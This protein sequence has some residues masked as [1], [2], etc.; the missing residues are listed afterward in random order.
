MKVLLT[1]ASGFIG[2]HARTLLEGQGH[3]VLAVSRRPGADAD[4]SEASLARALDACDG[5]LHLAGENVMARRWSERQKAKLRASR[6]ETTAKLV[7]ALARKRGGVLVCA[8]AVGYY[9][10]RGAEPVG[11][12]EPPGTDFLARLCQD[13]EAAAERAEAG[14]TRVARVRI[15]LVLGTDGG[16][17]ARMLPIA[18]LGLGGPLGSGEQVWPWVHV[19][20]LCALFA[21]LL[22]LDGARGPF[23]GTAPNPV[24]QRDF[25]RTLGRVLHRPAVLP[26]PAFALRVALGEAAGVLL[27]GVRA[28]PRSA[29][30]AGFTFRHPDL[31]RALRHLLPGASP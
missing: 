1:G 10:A 8:S 18:R 3:R 19:D 6:L 21:F 4:W 25:A 22:E 11:E 20:D 30:D 7:D 23:N 5:V 17:L 24:R 28:L 31:E 9:G 14:G 13:W 2:T 29:L 15:G 27:T 16:A 12:D 26:A